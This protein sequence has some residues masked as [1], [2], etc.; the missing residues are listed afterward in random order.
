MQNIHT[1]LI[2]T[3]SGTHG[4]ATRGANRNPKFRNSEIVRI[5]IWYSH[6]Q[7]LIFSDNFGQTQLPSNFFREKG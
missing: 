4:V 6:E 3:F 2:G 1:L 5:P 7:Q